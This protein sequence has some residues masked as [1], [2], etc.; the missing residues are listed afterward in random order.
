MIGPTFRIPGPPGGGSHSGDSQP[1]GGRA[2]AILGGNAA[3][4]LRIPT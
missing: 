1:D 4:V 2:E 3:S